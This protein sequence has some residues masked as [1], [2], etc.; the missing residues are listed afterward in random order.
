MQRCPKCGYREGAGWPNTLR[1]LGFLVL[2]AV[3]V[4]GIDRPTKGYRLIGFAALVLFFAGGIWEGFRNKK[5]VVE[6]K[7][8]D[9]VVSDRVKGHI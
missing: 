2:W 6:C 3:F 9:S 8:F 1:A 7:K 4:L 5:N